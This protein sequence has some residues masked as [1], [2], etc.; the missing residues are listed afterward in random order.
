MKGALK[1]TLALFLFSLCLIFGL[2]TK[3]SAKADTQALNEYFYLDTATR[4]GTITLSGTIQGVFSDSNNNRIVFY[5]PTLTQFLNEMYYVGRF[6]Y[7]NGTVYFYFYPRNTQDLY[8]TPYFYMTF[9]DNRSRYNSG[10]MFTGA[11]SGNDSVIMYITDIIKAFSNGFQ[12]ATLID[13]GQ[14]QP[15]SNI[16]D[17]T[18]YSYYFLT[19]CLYYGPQDTTYIDAYNAGQNSVIDDPMPYSL[20][21]L[22]EL[23]DNYESGY[24][25]GYDVGYSAGY[26]SGEMADPSRF[27]YNNILRTVFNTA[28]N[29]LNLSIVGPLKLI[30]FLILPLLLGL[31]AIV[32]KVFRS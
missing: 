30:H 12:L 27:E 23:N 16:L 1:L 6:L 32:L 14:S 5:I 9:N 26:S 13:N 29:I 15:A 20:Y 4:T 7:S 17:D 31:F 28:S 8:T 24:S 3:T 10:F 25:N 21:T 22:D 11:G 2:N 18:T 19:N